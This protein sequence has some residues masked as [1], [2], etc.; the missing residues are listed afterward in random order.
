MKHEIGLAAL[1]DVTD[2]VL[3]PDSTWHSGHR[4][5]FQR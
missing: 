2:L 4:P 3:E 1:A 5:P